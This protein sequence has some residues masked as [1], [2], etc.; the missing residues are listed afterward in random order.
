M[1]STARYQS[2]R[3]EKPVLAEQLKTPG[4]DGTETW[5]ETAV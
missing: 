5:K 1:D 3:Q 2:V 4:S